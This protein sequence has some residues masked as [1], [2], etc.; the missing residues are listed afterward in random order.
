MTVSGD[1]S[2]S[3]NEATI[4]RFASCSSASGTGSV[5]SRL[6]SPR[7]SSI[8][9]AVTSVRTSVVAC[10]EPRYSPADSPLYAP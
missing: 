3:A 7:I 8:A 9:G 5:R 1:S 2:E 6:I 4:A 10:Q